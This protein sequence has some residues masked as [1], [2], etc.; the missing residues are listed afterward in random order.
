MTPIRDGEYLEM[1]GGP[2]D[3]EKYV[4][5]TLAGLFPWMEDAEQC[6][7]AFVRFHDGSNYWLDKKNRRWVYQPERGPQCRGQSRSGA[8]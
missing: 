3:G 1:Y 2:K 6:P 8:G 5:R 7:P 4:V